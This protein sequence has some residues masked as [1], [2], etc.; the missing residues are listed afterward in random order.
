MSFEEHLARWEVLHG[1]SAS[2]LV[3]RW[4]RL[5]HVLARRLPVPP[6]LLTLLAPVVALGA[7]FVP[8]W[9]AALLVLLSALLDGLDG[10]VAVL[11]DRVTRVGAILDGV[12]DRVCDGLY[13]LLLVRFGGSIWLAIVCAAGIV[14]LEGTRLVLRRAVVVTVAERP[15]RVLACAFGVMSVP[16]AGLALQAVASGVAL[17][18]LSWGLRVRPS[19][20]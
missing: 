14:L 1:V 6:T 17:A 15:T 3:V 13:L 12:G 8:A 7:L 16:T 18:Q 2:P 10:A 11:R 5:V 4:L 20:G 19:G 9:A